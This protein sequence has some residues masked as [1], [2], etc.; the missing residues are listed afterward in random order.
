MRNDFRPVIDLVTNQTTI[1]SH[2]DPDVVQERSAR[3]TLR[4]DDGIAT[5]TLDH[6]PADINT[7][8]IFESLRPAALGRRQETLQR[9]DYQASSPVDITVD[10]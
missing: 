1:E 8:D 5:A 7:L 3:A 2:L 10:R 6:L 9:V 4:V